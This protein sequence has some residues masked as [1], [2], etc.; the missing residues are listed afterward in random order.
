D[1]SVVIPIYNEEGILSASI[2]DLTEKLSTS[3][4]LEHLTF[5]IILAENGSVDRTVEVARR[6][7]L[8]HPEL[9]MIHSDTPD[10][11]KALKLGILSAR[12]EYVICD[13]IDLCDVD[14]YER[15]IYRLREEG[16]DLVVGSK[17]LERSFDKRPPFRRAATHVINGMLRVFVG[18]R[19]TDTHGLKAFRREALLPIINKC[20]VGKDMFAS[21]LVIRTEREDGLR[22]TEIPV[23][24]IEKRAPSIRLT[25]RVPGVLK[26]IAKLTWEIRLHNR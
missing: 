24:V 14:F 16:Y 4:K 17:T 18:F 10:Y 5:E 2:A 11:G 12:G 3:K 7:M 6:L 8:R 9:R 13:E 25:K 21:E 20:V 15:A 23:E 22:N 1:V 26:H 19:G